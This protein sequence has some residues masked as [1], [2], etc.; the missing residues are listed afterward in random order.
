MKQQDEVSHLFQ[1][2]KFVQTSALH[3]SGLKCVLQCSASTSTW[4]DR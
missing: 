2:N 1:I 4:Y 3:S